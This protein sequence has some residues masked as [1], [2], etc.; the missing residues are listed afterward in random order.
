MK[1][2]KLL[3]LAFLF[4]GTLLHGQGFKK[5]YEH[6]VDRSLLELFDQEEATH[7]LSRE[8]GFMVINTPE[9][10]R[11]VSGD[12]GKEM[13]KGEHMEKSAGN[14]ILSNI[15]GQNT[16]GAL[17][18]GEALKE[19]SGFYAFEK[20]EVVIFLDWTLDENV[21]RAFDA[22][23]G[24]AL[25]E[26]SDLRFTPGK[27][28]QMNSLLMSMAVTSV[29]ESSVPLYGATPSG[30]HYSIDL[31]GP[32]HH[33]S[34]H[35]RAFITPL[36]GTGSFLLKTGDRH[37]CLDMATGEKRWTY[38]GY[39]VNIAEH[40]MLAGG[41]EVLLV[42]FNP[43]WFAK[44]ENLIIKLDAQTGEELMRIRHLN[45]YVKERTY[46]Y[47]D[48]L[49]LDY[50]GV[51]VY[52]LSTGERMFV[53]VDERAIKSSNTMTSLFGENNGEKNKTSV[54]LPSLVKEGILYTGTRKMG[55]KDYPLMGGSRNPIFHAWDLSTGERLWSSS[56]MEHKSEILDAAHGMLIL[57][58]PEG[59][60]KNR[61]Y[62][63]DLAE[64]K[65]IGETEKIKHYLLRNGA[66]HMITDNAFIFSGKKG[67][68]AYHPESWK[69]MHR[70]DI[71]KAGIGKIQAMDVYG[72][73]LFV[74]GDKGVAFYDAAGEFQDA[75]KI[76]R[77]EGSVWSGQR[78]IA[79]TKDDVVAV[80]L[81]SGDIRGKIPIKGSFLFSD[82]L[83]F[84]LFRK[85]PFYQQYVLQ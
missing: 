43:S 55:K 10:Y 5:I 84:W 33:G 75:L 2:F 38:S 62:G 66:G 50:F 61:F 77:L 6:Q 12:D 74:V 14:Q 60:G 28:Q 76:K 51:E 22:E 8:N 83:R 42:N 71:R 73:G 58:E 49:I 64:G 79:F 15:V 44:S 53:T 7:Y 54:A 30:V 47:K 70:I 35:A 24:E 39:P 78:L 69:L 65:K 46:V 13:V 11:I 32:A 3:L 4:T 18:D 20:E 25:W 19:S 37:V 41:R 59:F 56:E 57:K 36:E 29:V 82:D 85:G 27:D 67:L 63:L 80:D 17:S 26:R 1:M 45:N 52:D 68:Y 16:F 9:T 40:H 72:K 48:R 23:S 81:Q 21:I 34:D 31:S